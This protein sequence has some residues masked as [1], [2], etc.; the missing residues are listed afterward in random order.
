M[1]FRKK[2]FLLIN[3]M[4]RREAM[5]FLSNLPVSEESPLVVRVEESSRTLEQNALL[6]PLLQAFAKQIK[7]PVNG[8]MASLTEDAWKDI[9]SSTFREEVVRMA[10]YRG[11]MILVGQRTSKMGKK[12]FSEFI[13]YIY[14]EGAELGVNFEYKSH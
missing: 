4:V 8:E 14:S 12:E 2:M 13:E 9:L 11:K 10:I 1:E 7:L 3:P 5:V 6:W